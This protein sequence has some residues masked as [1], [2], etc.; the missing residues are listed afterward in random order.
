MVSLFEGKKIIISYYNSIVGIKGENMSTIDLLKRSYL[1][2]SS[3]I[4]KQ[5]YFN[6]NY[7]IYNLWEKENVKICGEKKKNP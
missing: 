6:C 4:I 5:S 7:D 1:N 3:Q 2:Y